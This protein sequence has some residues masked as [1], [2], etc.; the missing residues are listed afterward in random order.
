M[1]EAHRL[2][3]NTVSEADFQLTIRSWARLGG[4]LVYCT[5][6]SR[7][8]P[9]GYPDLVLVHAVRGWCVFAENKSATGRLRPDQ[10]T[11]L[12]ALAAVA[13]VSPR[14]AV[15]LWRPVDGDTIRNFLLG[16]TD[17]PPGRYLEAQ[18]T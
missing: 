18:R 1:T 11:W 5:Y 13:T 16:V 8:S 9:H 15:C 17:D 4:W 12:S 10:H 2:V 6:D 7:R 3:L 14:L